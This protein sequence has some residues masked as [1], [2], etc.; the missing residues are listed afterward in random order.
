M[1]NL[2]NAI[3]RVKD[4][5]SLYWMFYHP[6]DVQEYEIVE[7]R[8]NGHEGLVNKFIPPIGWTLH[9]IQWDD[10]FFIRRLQLMRK[11][12]VEDMLCEMLRFAAKNDA[13]LH[14]WEAGG[15]LAPDGFHP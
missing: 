15:D 9:R 11:Q 13:Q 5:S 3:A 6:D 2:D 8:F 4:G 12:D 10:T 1:T 14:S 7:V